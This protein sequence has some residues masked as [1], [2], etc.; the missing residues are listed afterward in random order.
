MGNFLNEV[1]NPFQL[2]LTK[3]PLGGV[4]LGLWLVRAAL[5]ITLKR[6]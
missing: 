6:G 2:S 3:H 4:T 5:S 1:N